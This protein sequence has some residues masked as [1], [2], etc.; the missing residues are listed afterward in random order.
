MIWLFGKFSSLLLQIKKFKLIREKTF[1]VSGPTSMDVTGND[2]L[3]VRTK[4]EGKYW[5]RVINRLTGDLINKIPSMC[6][7]YRVRV[8]KYPQDQDYAFESCV[9]CEQVYGHNINTLES[10]SIHKGSKIIRIC[11]GPG[12]SL[13]L[14]TKDWKLHKLEWDKR[15]GGAQ[16]VF[17]HDIP[18]GPGKIGLRLCYVECHDIFMYTVKDLEEDEDYEI[19]AV[20]L[21]TGNIV[22]RL[23]S[24]VDGLIIKPESI[25]CDSEGNAY[26]DDLQNNR[27][28]K[29]NSLTSE[30]LSILLFD[31]KENEKKNLNLISIRW[32]N[33]EPNLTVRTGKHISTYLV[34]K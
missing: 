33:T 11:D 27:I 5:I 4:E 12:G 20:K 21:G 19:I 34:P 25:T 14:V 6:D 31:G 16:L 18:P 1:P 2:L 32:S 26:V 3:L 15:Q 13:L 29:I 7:H 10:L 22:W 28:L 24:P 9:T 30:I 8:K 17:V 23:S